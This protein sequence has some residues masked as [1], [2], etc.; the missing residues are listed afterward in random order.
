MLLNTG[1]TVLKIFILGGISLNI[2]S[3]ILFNGDTRAEP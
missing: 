1:I 2:R 3:E